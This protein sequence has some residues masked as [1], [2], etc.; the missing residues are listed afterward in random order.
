M[1]GDIQ[2]VACVDYY[3]NACYLLRKQSYAI[4]RVVHACPVTPGVLSA[5]YTRPAASRLEHPSILQ[6]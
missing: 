3:D 4:W 5:H 1:K 6:H 2:T